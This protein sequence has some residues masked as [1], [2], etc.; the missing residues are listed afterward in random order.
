MNLTN[1][2]TAIQ[3]TTS[4]TGRYAASRE[5]FIGFHAHIKSQLEADQYEHWDIRVSDV[6]ELNKFVIEITGQ[7]Y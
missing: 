1:L 7:D 4:L 5:I 3:N 2:N 6:T